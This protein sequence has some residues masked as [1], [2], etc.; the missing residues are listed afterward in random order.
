[1]TEPTLRINCWSGPRNVSTALMRSFAQRA[2]ARVVDEPL[3]GHYLLTTGA[4]HPG[5]DEL[6]ELLETDSE[7]IIRATILGPCDRAVLF[8]KQMVHHLTPDL[9]LTFL[10]ACVNVLLIRDPAEVISSLVHQLPAPTMRDVGLERQMALFADLRGRGQEPPVLDS[11]QLLLAP[12]HVLRDLCERVGIPWDA[13]MLSWPAGPHPA[14]GPWG[15]YWYESLWRS[16]GFAPYEPRTR[17]VPDSCRDLLA[18]CR[19]YYDELAKH[20]LGASNAEAR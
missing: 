6:V 16:T 9:D 18:E 8:L 2:D 1:M 13:A 12:E 3:Y 10:D 20:A 11:R 17:E 15:R 14:D 5:R 7:T 19:T 4:P